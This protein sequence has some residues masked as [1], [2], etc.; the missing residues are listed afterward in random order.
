[1]TYAEY[2]AA[3]EKSEVK[4][5]YLR[6][7]VFAMVGG[8]PEHGRL[9]SNLIHELGKALGR[10]PCVVYSSNVRVRILATDLSTYPD[11][12]VVCGKLEPAPDDRNAIAN[13]TLIV[14]V[15]SD[16]TE[17]QDRGE[18]FA[19]YRRLPSLREYL[20]VS[21]H[22]IRLEVYR[23]Q[24]DFW[25]LAEAGPGQRLRLDSLDVALSVDDVYFDP[26]LRPPG[27]LA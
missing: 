22:S 7:E 27:D 3:E 15:L 11:A 6:G 24:G 25:V 20:L 12:T 14:E 26:F 21:Q 1:M 10:R 13:P 17:A 8:T 19:H 23:R 5:E 18:K 16:S 9:A 2:L 4:H